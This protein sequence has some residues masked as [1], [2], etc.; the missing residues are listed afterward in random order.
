MFNIWGVG[1]ISDITKLAIRMRKI[2]SMNYT[3]A[4]LIKLFSHKPYELKTII[5][6]V[7]E[8]LNCNMV[9]VSNSRFTGG[10]NA[11]SPSYKSQ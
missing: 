2:G 9:T 3:V 10:K 11:N 7:E 6:G 5:D 4:S 1:L 8:L